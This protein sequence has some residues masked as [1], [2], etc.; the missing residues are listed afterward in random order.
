LSRIL[1]ELNEL[2]GMLL[3]PL[4]NSAGFG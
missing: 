4:G 2:V 1:S 3:L